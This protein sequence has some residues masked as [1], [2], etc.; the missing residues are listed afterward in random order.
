MAIDLRL[1]WATMLLTFCQSC[2]TFTGFLKIS[3][4]SQA[5]FKAQ[6]WSY[7]AVNWPWK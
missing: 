6:L 2:K 1:I 4:Y 7:K 3:P 5:Q